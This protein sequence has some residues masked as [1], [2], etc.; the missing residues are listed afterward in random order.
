MYHCY[1]IMMDVPSYVYFTHVSFLTPLYTMCQEV[2]A[3]LAVVETVEEFNFLHG[4]FTNS[5]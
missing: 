4:I 5:K 2:D 3:T 1:S